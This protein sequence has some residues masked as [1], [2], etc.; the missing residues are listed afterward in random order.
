MCHDWGLGK[1]LEMV[2]AHRVRPA[3]PSTRPVDQQEGTYVDTS[4]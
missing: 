1:H 4:P 3:R 2:Q